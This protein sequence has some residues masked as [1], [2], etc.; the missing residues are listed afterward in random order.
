MALPNSWF[1]EIGLIDIGTYKTG[2]LSFYYERYGLPGAV[3]EARTYG[4][5]RGMLLQQAT[6]AAPYSI[7]S[8]YCNLVR[9][10]HVASAPRNIDC[11]VRVH[12][13][14]FRAMTRKAALAVS[15]SPEFGA[16]WVSPPALH[17]PLLAFCQSWNKL[18]CLSIFIY[19]KVVV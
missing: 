15:P 9:D 14:S 7:H 1:N 19:N 10:R 11:T 2:T 8:T 4:S 18:L 6:A 3:Y 16:M 12:R 5:V 13:E 17:Q